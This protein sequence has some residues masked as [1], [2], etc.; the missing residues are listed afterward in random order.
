MRCVEEVCEEEA[1]KLE[2]ER[3]DEAAGERDEGPCG[4]VVDDHVAVDVLG[5]WS[6]HSGIPIWGDGVGLSICI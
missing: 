2:E 4:Q 1:D 3:D 6:M 5:S